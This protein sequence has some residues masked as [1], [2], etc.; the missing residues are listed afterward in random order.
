MCVC[1]YVH[2]HSNAAAAAAP[3]WRQRRS[4]H[5]TTNV[6]SGELHLPFQLRRRSVVVVVKRVACLPACLEQVFRCCCLVFSYHSQA[7]A[8]DL[9]RMGEA[10]VVVVI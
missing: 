9:V 6:A 1:A 7:E 3:V 5:R 4:C 10:A 8:I 2:E